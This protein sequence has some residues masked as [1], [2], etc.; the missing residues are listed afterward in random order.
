MTE[1]RTG[2]Y[3]AFVFDLYG[4][5]VDIRTDEDAAGL[6]RGL[7]EFYGSLGA[8]YKPSELKRNYRRMVS[9]ETERQQRAGRERYGETYLAE[10]DLTAVFRQLYAE[11]GVRCSEERGVLTAV[12]FRILSRR[13]LKVYEGVRETLLA[14]RRAGKGVYL[15]SNAQRDFTRPEIELTG[16]AT[17]STGS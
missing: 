4:T 8:H 2:K 17:A 11:R 9:L 14:L 5:L 10:P 15:L 3:D 12:L 16:L 7:S 1:D 13:K 6:W